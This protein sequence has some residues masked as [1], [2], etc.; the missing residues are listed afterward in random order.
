MRR[1]NKKRKTR[2]KWKKERERRMRKRKRTMRRRKSKRKSGGKIPGMFSSPLHWPNC[3][4][5]DE[6]VVGA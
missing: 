3:L 1:K 2:R 4:S 5:D 6:A